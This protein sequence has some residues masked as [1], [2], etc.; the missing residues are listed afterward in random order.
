MNSEEK[1]IAVLTYTITMFTND[2]GIIFSTSMYLHFYDLECIDII[3]SK[4]F[5]H[6][7]SSC[8]HDTNKRT[9]IRLTDLFSLDKFST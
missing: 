7:L 1:K 5:F 3:I 8:I 9:D 6:S 4:K 2:R